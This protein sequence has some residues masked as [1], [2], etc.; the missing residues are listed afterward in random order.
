MEG[1]RSRC[2]NLPRCKYANTEIQISA[3]PHKRLVEDCTRMRDKSAFSDVTLKV[4]D[5]S[6]FPC[7]KFILAARSEVFR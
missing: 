5:R 2:A 1:G 4:G 7:S 6:S 3:A